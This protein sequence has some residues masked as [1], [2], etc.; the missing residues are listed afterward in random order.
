MSCVCPEKV[1]EFRRRAWQNNGEETYALS[2]LIWKI[3]ASLGGMTVGAFS[4]FI[5][6]SL[7]LETWLTRPPVYRADESGAEKLGIPFETV[8]FPTDGGLT[9]RGWFFPAGY[10]EAPAIIYAHSSGHDLREGLPLVSALHGAGY[11]ML[12][13]SYR[14]H[15]FSDPT[16]KGHTYGYT[17]SKDISAAVRYLKGRRDVGSVGVIGYSLGASS[18]ILSAASSPEIRAV[19]AVAPFACPKDLW[20]ANRPLFIPVPFLEVVLRLAELQKGIRL[21]A[22]CADEAARRLPPR[23]LLLIQGTEDQYIPMEQTEKILRAAESSWT[24]WLI[25]GAGHKEVLGLGLL[26]R[27]QELLTFLEAALR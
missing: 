8:E 12:L 24:L 14:G 10:K 17:E 16:G 5:A 1:P 18:A 13:F 6:V 22:L 26:R 2:G 19:V 20:Y 9:L 27:Q 23:A 11:H 7:V 15:G 21:D 3:T 4:I 25:E